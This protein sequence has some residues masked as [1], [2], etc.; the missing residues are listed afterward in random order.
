MTPEHA[1]YSKH[2]NLK[3]AADE[4]GMKWQTLYCKLKSQGVSVCG[5]KLKYGTDRDKLGA[6][7]ESI[8][9]S[10]IHFAQNCNS[11]EFQSKVDFFVN[12]KKVD[13]KTS[14]PR[15]LNK[16]F[17]ALSWSFSFKRQSIIAD[18][19][20]CFCLDED[21]KIEHILLV[22]SE[23]F[24]GLKTISVSRIGT[25]KWLDYA[26]DKNDL[27]EFFSNIPT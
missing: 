7:G 21:K 17:K 22:P 12:G 4:I 13:V 8:F 24:H 5:D 1:A 9:Q 14:L 2:K 23:F 3:L 18:Y 25:S 16:R 26:V 10:I 27:V 20:V 11:K 15:Q 6:L 19:I